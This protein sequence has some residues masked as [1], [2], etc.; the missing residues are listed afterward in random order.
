MCN[1]YYIIYS[2]VRNKRNLKKPQKQQQSSLSSAVAAADVRKKKKKNQ[3][4]AP[5]TRTVFHATAAT[6]AALHVL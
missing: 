5:A 4:D 1:L 6:A 2:P 3:E